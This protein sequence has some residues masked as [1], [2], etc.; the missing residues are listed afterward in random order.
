MPS[1]MQDISYFL[2]YNHLFFHGIS[3]FDILIFCRFYA[4]LVEGL[5]CEILARS[6]GCHLMV[7]QVTQNQI[8]VGYSHKLYATLVLMYLEGRTPLPIQGSVAGF[9]LIFLFW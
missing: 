7:S 4:T 1:V 8:L 2:L 5:Q 9:V 3:K 6:F